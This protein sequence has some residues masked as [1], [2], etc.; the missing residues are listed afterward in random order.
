MKNISLGQHQVPQTPLG[1]R[2]GYNEVALATPRTLTLLRACA[3]G[4]GGE[5]RL[6]DLNAGLL[7]NFLIALALFGIAL[8]ICW[9]C[10]FLEKH[11]WWQRFPRLRLWARLCHRDR[12]EEEKHFHWCLW[13]GCALLTTC[14]LVW[15]RFNP[16]AG[17]LAQIEN[18]MDTSNFDTAA[19]IRIV[20]TARARGFW[21]FVMCA[22]VLFAVSLLRLL[23]H[24]RLRVG[25]RPPKIDEE[26]PCSSAWRFMVVFL[27]T[28]AGAAASF[29]AFVFWQGEFSTSFERQKQ[30]ASDLGF[31]SGVVAS[32]TS[33]VFCMR[34]ILSWIGPMTITL[35]LS[36]SS[37]L[38]SA[39]LCKVKGRANR[40]LNSVVLGIVLTQ[41]VTA[42]I[43][44]IAYFH[45]GYASTILLWLLF[46]TT[47]FRMLLMLLPFLQNNSK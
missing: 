16:L 8:V 2:S 6:D 5:D 22:A 33:A 23:Q 43:L 15:M 17:Q 21:V 35:S 27:L 38:F 1:Q 42:L 31:L 13:M 3:Q 45:S 30:H 11:C 41:E 14:G 19:A 32:S 25:L 46:C 12:L 37:I 39:S 44:A 26:S 4:A 28:E 9:S 10:G 40:S 34:V 47:A 7:E 18:T 36:T 24:V 29:L 20:E